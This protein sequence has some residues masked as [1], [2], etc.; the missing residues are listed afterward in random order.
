LRVCTAWGSAHQFLVYLNR[1]AS[2]WPLP[3]EENIRRIVCPVAGTSR[4]ARYAYEQVTLPRRLQPDRVDIVH[5]LGYVG[6]LFTSCPSVVTIHDLNYRVCP[7]SAARRA[8]LAFFV[9]LPAARSEACCS[10]WRLYRCQPGRC[11]SQAKPI[12]MRE[13]VEEDVSDKLF[14]NKATLY[15]CSG[16][17][18]PDGPG[19]LGRKRM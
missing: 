8:R 10:G 19:S 7:M 9:R 12:C 5:S 1:A 18:F 17:P 13:G 14:E 3:A 2:D 16:R 11:S 15:F 6:P 4:W